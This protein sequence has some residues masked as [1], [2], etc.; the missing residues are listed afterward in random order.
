MV[1]KWFGH[2]LPITMEH[3][4]L[5]KQACTVMRSKQIFQKLL[6]EI[7]CMLYC[8]FFKMT[9]ERTAVKVLEGC[10]ICCA[11]HF[12]PSFCSDSPVW[13]WLYWACKS[14]SYLSWFSDLTLVVVFLPHRPV[15]LIRFFGLTYDDFVWFSEQ[16]MFGSGLPLPASLYLFWNNVFSL[17][18]SKDCCVP[19]PRCP[20]ST[21]I[22]TYL[23]WKKNHS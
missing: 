6:K 9:R 2:S 12:S 14:I 7:S 10:W 21:G 11:C 13:H 23:A 18:I 4:R 3:E 20:S 19:W 1:P 15:A 17:N 5:W 8:F 22:L 16:D